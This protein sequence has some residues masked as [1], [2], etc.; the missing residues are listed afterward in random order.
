VDA[1]F[2]HNGGSAAVLV[3]RIAGQAEAADEAA[4]GHLFLVVVGDDA[5][6]IELEVQSGRLRFAFQCPHQAQQRGDRGKTVGERAGDGVGVLY[7]QARQ[8]Q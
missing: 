3:E 4:I 5:D 8:H 7:P 2:F 1:P 6:G